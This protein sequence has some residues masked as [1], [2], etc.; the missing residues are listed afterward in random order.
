MQND[1]G[2]KKLPLATILVLYILPILIVE[3]PIV[4]MDYLGDNVRTWFLYTHII[5]LIVIFLSIRWLGLGRAILIFIITIIALTLTSENV[6]LPPRPRAYE[7]EHMSGCHSIAIALSRYAEDHEGQ[8]P[9]DTDILLDGNYLTFFPHNVISGEP[10]TYVQMEDIPFG[11]EYFEGNFTYLPVYEGDQVIGYYLIAYGYQNRAGM[12]VDGDGDDDHV[13]LVLD[14]TMMDGQES[15]VE[16]GDF[17]Y[18]LPSLEEL[19]QD[20]VQDAPDTD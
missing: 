16:P 6:R 9:P 3:F 2:K 5:A 15:D 8:Y 10:G 20:H 7:V 14:S 12:D 17:E 19:L 11:S 18:I 13:I 4:F 1:K